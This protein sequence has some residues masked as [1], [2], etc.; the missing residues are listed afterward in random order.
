[1]AVMVGAP[2]A[3]KID[4][5]TKAEA[6]GLF[7]DKRLGQ[8]GSCNHSQFK[9]APYS[10]LTTARRLEN[11]DNSEPAFVL[12]TAKADLS[13]LDGRLVAEY[14]TASKKTIGMRVGEPLLYLGQSSLAVTTVAYS[15]GD[16]SNFCIQ[17]A[18]ELDADEYSAAWDAGRLV[19]FVRV[20][21]TSDSDHHIEML[22]EVDN[23]YYDSNSRFTWKAETDNNDTYIHINCTESGLYVTGAYAY[24]F[25]DQSND[26]PREALFGFTGGTVDG[27]GY[28]IVL[29]GSWSSYSASFSEVT[30]K[31]AVGGGFGSESGGSACGSALD[32]QY[33][34][35]TV[36]Y[37]SPPFYPSLRMCM[38]SC[39]M[40][41]STT[42]SSY[43]NGYCAY[44]Y[45]TGIGSISSNADSP[46]VTNAKVT[47]P[48][49]DW[50]IFAEGIYNTASGTAT[51]NIETSLVSNGSKGD[52]VRECQASNNYAQQ[53]LMTTV[54]SFGPGNTTWAVG[55]HAGSTA[56]SGNSAYIKAIKIG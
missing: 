4:S 50:L 10:H 14:G 9:V 27:N 26:S 17:D 39:N 18:L 48:P 3:T 20:T 13:V 12:G 22:E 6:D 54:H 33:N 55:M 21:D 1:M 52:Y 37:A 53:V 42:S 5:Y 23:G 43:P 15:G 49:G 35:T 56:T 46:T 19:V 45:Q 44:G 38:S 2:P 7:L 51:H 11:I 8:A 41:T 36:S 34:N 31:F 25:L 24:A 30:N 16:M 29:P 28:N 32:C 47:L 40:W